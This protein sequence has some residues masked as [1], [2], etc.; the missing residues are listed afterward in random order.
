[1]YFSLNIISGNPDQIIRILMKFYIVWLS[2]K[3]P[4]TFWLS[5]SSSSYML[6]KLYSNL[7]IGLNI[8][9]WKVYYVWKITNDVKVV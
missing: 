6:K 8:W 7:L 4:S 3:C 5:Y 1:M 2:S 9:T